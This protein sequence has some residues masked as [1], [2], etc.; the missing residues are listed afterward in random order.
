[1]MNLSADNQAL[2]KEKQINEEEILRQVQLLRSGTPFTS[3]EAACTPGQG[4]TV[5]QDEE[6]E[7]AIGVF[8]EAKNRLKLTKFVP[9]SGA[10]SRMFKHLFS[11]QL[12]STLCQQFF[13]EIDRF[14]FYP[15]IEQSCGKPESTETW[16]LNVID[17]LLSEDGLNF[18]KLPK[19]AIPFHSY[20][21]GARNAFIEHL[22]E[23]LGYSVSQQGGEV[24]FTVTKALSAYSREHI[25]NHA[26]NLTKERKLLVSYSEQFQNT[27]TVALDEQNELVHLADGRLLFR[28]GGHG[29]LIKNLAMIDAD[30]VFIKNIDNVVPD[31]Q[32]ET[33]YKWKKA[34]AGTL[35]MLVERRDELLRALKEGNR[36]AAHE[37]HSFYNKYF[38]LDEVSFGSIDELMALLDRPIRIGGMV[39]NQGEPGGGPYWTES[40]GRLSAQIVEAS[41]IDLDNSEQRE[42]VAT[43]SHFNPVDIVCNIKK[44]D[45][46]NYNLDQFIDH[47]QSFIT[48]KSIEGKEV[49][50]LEHPGLWNGGMA[51][52]LT[53][54]VEVPLA[55]FAP[56]K[57]VNDLLRDEHQ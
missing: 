34:L 9:A 47:N 56:V 1:M 37:A 55:T 51:G 35:L 57:T 7:L 28:P 45:G 31:A 12:D 25:L 33:T 24:H 30:V 53:L 40:M 42:I 4:I 50:S 5:L 44:L 52:W 10:A 54:F 22:H 26:Q 23:S 6:V 3:V 20:P 48:H 49:K 13:S 39:R 19:G 46:Q 29:S 2:L 36:T 18:G 8:N 43:A 16:Q 38:A 11:K 14:P 27:D 32:K 15:E 41:Q 17:F 21:D